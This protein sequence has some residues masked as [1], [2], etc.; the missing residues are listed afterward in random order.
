MSWEDRGGWRERANSAFWIS[1]DGREKISSSTVACLR[2]MFRWWKILCWIFHC[3]H[4]ATATVERSFKPE[5]LWEKMT[6]S[7]R[8]VFIFLSYYFVVFFFPPQLLSS[9]STMVFPST[10]F[11]DTR[12]IFRFK[13]IFG[14]TPLPVATAAAYRFVIWLT[15]C[16][17]TYRSVGNSRPF[18]WCGLRS[19]QQPRK[20]PQRWR[21]RNYGWKKYIQNN[22]RQYNGAKR[23]V[24]RLCKLI[25]WWISHSGRKKSWIMS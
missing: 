21:K 7:M 15:C 13:V 14:L 12:K 10:I 6:K 1:A 23:E 4:L 19:A 17:A 5:W 9:N 22:A 11:Y 25:V 8:L 2:I 24:Q 3:L 16:G 18:S 20:S